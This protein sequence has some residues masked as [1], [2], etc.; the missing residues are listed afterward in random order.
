MCL[1][2]H[3][4]MVKHLHTSIVNLHIKTEQNVGLTV[5]VYFLCTVIHLLLCIG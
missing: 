2:M 4:D 1:L 5:S 3:R